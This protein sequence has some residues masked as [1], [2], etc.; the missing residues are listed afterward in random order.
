[1]LKIKIFTIANLLFISFLF[2]D[3][4]WHIQNLKQLLETQFE[5]KQL[6]LLATKTHQIEARV[7]HLSESLMELSNEKFFTDALRDFSNSFKTVSAELKNKISYDESV[8]IVKNYYNEVYQAHYK[9][10]HKTESGPG[11]SELTSSFSDTTRLLQYAYI[12]KKDQQSNK[13]LLTNLYNKVHA[14]YHPVLKN[15]VKSLNVSDLYFIDKLGN[16]IYTSSKGIDFAA[17]VKK[18]ILSKSSLAEI[19]LNNKIHITQL[20]SYQ[21]DYDRENL[22]I[23]IPL[24]E[25]GHLAFRLQPSQIAAEI[26]SNPTTKNYILYKSQSRSHLS[27]IV[28]ILDEQWYLS[29][30][31]IRFSDYILVQDYQNEL[32]HKSAILILIF[33]LISAIFIGIFLNPIIN[34]IK[35]LKLRSSSL[36][37]KVDEM[38]KLVENDL[39]QTENFSD[40]TY[41]LFER[42]KKMY[43]SLQKLNDAYSLVG[44]AIEQS[45]QKSLQLNDTLGELQVRLITLKKLQLDKMVELEEQSHK[46]VQRTMIIHNVDEKLKIMHDL[47]FQMKIAA[48]NAN[49]EANRLGEEGKSFGVIAKE[50]STIVQNSIKLNTD[51]NQIVESL[52]IQS[53]QDGKSNQ[54]FI[55][56]MMNVSQKEI[57]SASDYAAESLESINK[58]NEYINK[59]VI[60]SFGSKELIRK[61]LTLSNEVETMSQDVHQFSVDGVFHAKSKVLLVQSIFQFVGLQYRDIDFAMGLIAGKYQS[62]K[63]KTAPS[64]QEEKI[65][66]RIK[67]DDIAA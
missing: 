50:F 32:T 31:A 28:K 58:I 34:T 13:L 25:I 64:Q 5:Q 60:L 12:A 45:K 35:F 44:S 26:S 16:I 17:D 53:M 61:Q 1:M 63:P 55:D 42:I 57:N 22:F 18:D 38:L 29:A 43:S 19:Y 36:D 41:N 40:K 52:K 33:M 11:Y 49:V 3:S 30:P 21:L 37:L 39:P 24:G 67:N 7:K 15:I 46:I 54:Q 14:Q 47:T 56:K 20:K 65:I 66:Q 62:Q 6:N 23:G 51:L 4:F 2:V 27:R 10:I 48:F 8:A 9:E 59:L